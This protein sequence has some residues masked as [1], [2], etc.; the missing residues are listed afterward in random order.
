MPFF[1]RRRANRSNQQNQQQAVEQGFRTMRGTVVSQGLAVD[2]EPTPAEEQNTQTGAQTEA[3]GTLMQTAAARLP[4]AQAASAAA[5]SPVQDQ[6]PTKKTYKQR[7]EDQ[8]RDRLAQQFNPDADHASY[9]MMEQL[10]NQD[11]EK[12]NSM[13]ADRVSRAVDAHVDLRVLRSFSQG[14]RTDKKGRVLRK[15]RDRKAADDAFLEDY[16]SADVQRRWP[17]LE[18]MTREI[19]NMDIT[20]GMTAEAYLEKHMAESYE[21]SSRLVYFENVMKDPVNKPFF[22]AMP[23]YQ[24]EL[25]NEKL[26]QLME[27]Y[28]LALNAKAMLKGFALDKRTYYESTDLEMARMQDNVISTALTQRLAQLQQGEE[29]I[30][31]RDAEQEIGRLISE[32]EPGAAEK[33][34]QEQAAAEGA[35]APQTDA[36]TAE[37]RRAVDAKPAVYE[38][39]KTMLDDLAAKRSQIGASWKAMRRK[40][41][42]AQTLCALYEGAASPQEIRRRDKAIEKGEAYEAEAG[43][44]ASELAA[45]TNAMDFFLKDEPLSAPGREMLISSGYVRELAKKRFTEEGGIVEK[46]DAAYRSEIA[47][48]SNMTQARA[49]ALVELQLRQSKDEGAKLNSL[50]I[51]NRFDGLSGDYVEYFHELDRS[52]T[53]MSEVQAN[54]KKSSYSKSSASAYVSEGGVDEIQAHMMGVFLNYLT[55]PECIQYFREMLPNVKDAAV[56]GGNLESAVA[57]LSQMLMIKFGANYISVAQETQKNAYRNNDATRAVATEACRTLLCISGMPGVITP[58]NEAQLPATIKAILDQYR[59]GLQTVLKGVS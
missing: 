10:T 42:A 26:N 57:Y 50:L 31:D 30:Y 13:T 39:Y 19:L 59:A 38:E 36:Y 25:L 37:F 33:A 27:P 44:I 29:A 49:A 22:D 40:A 1:R 21:R 56:F 34:P 2:P 35:A 41:A 54:M 51:G 43:R 4:Q 6:E 47:K 16:I 11:A 55:S 45:C 9:N 24:L 3:N 5:G 7:R 46:S 12:K 15:D 28:S 48:G 32:T 52:G 8:K 20:L 14:Y 58:E 23:Q 18:R 17:H 53:D